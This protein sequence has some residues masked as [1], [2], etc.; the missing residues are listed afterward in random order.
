MSP[1]QGPTD[2][3]PRGWWHTLRDAVKAFRE[4]DRTDDAAALTYYTVLALFP[5]MIVLIS[6][7]GVFGDTGTVDS[8][9]AIADDLGSS[10]AVDVIEEPVNNIVESSSAAGLGLILGIAGGLFSASGYVGAF[11]RASNEIYGVEDDRPFW[12][13]RPLQIGITFVMTTI[14]AFVLV[15]L[16]L[17]GPLAEAIGNE[18]GLGDTALTIF[19]IA[20]WPILFAMVVLVIGLLYRWSPD[21]GHEGLR[22]ILPG[23]ALATVLWVF[24]S[25]GFSFY[26]A[27]FGSYANTYGSLAGV[28]VFLVWLW[29]TNVAVLLGAQFARELERT[30]EAAAVP[31]APDEPVPLDPVDRELAPHYSPLTPEDT[32]QGSSAPGAA[33]AAAPGVPAGTD[34]S[35]ERR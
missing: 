18:V 17:T 19:G 8:L 20:K 35:S 31:F 24:A 4:N 23:S 32:T 9:L 21:T 14:L 3:T 28:I 7:L 27:N 6:L 13:A 15:A 26:V 33:E 25:V 10:S 12:K 11:M 1:I 16:V 2:V 22:W 5:G 34:D 30:A 29:L